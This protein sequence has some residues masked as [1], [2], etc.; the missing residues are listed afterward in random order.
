MD[1]KKDFIFSDNFFVKEID[2]DGKKFDRG[3][4][5]A[6]SESFN[7]ELT[8]DVNSELFPVDH[9]DR[10]VLAIT[11][12]LLPPSAKKAALKI[13]EDYDANMSEPNQN[14]LEQ[15][16]KESD[17]SWRSIISGAESSIADQFDYVMYGKIYRF[18]DS[19]GSK[20]SVFFSFGGLLMCLEGDYSPLQNFTVGECVYLLL[21]K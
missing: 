13:R 4:I 12:T 8:L 6:R 2:K 18:D 20:V 3:K 16:R 21:K 5:G 1:N 14:D 9:S 10:L 11:S 19:I 7:V 17:V 15:Q